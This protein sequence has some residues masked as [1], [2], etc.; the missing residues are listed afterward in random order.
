MA[1]SL[2]IK[3][4]IPDGELVVEHGGQQ[5]VERPALVFQLQ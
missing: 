5:V 1:R 2:P 3:K 4:G